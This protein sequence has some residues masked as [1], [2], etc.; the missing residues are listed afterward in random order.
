ADEVIAPWKAFLDR[1]GLDELLVIPDEELA[2]IPFGLLPF[3]DGCLLDRFAIA[4]APSL[5]AWLTPASRAYGE[6]PLFSLANPA[7]GEPGGGLPFAEKEAETLAGLFPGGPEPFVDAAAKRSV[8][9]ELADRA[10][11]LHLATHTRLVPGD[12]LSSALLLT[13][14]EEEGD[15]GRLTAAEI[16]ALPLACELAVLSACETAV[17]EGGDGL[18]FLSLARAFL[19]AGAEAVAATFWR[20]SDI[21]TAITVRNLFLNLAD[22][23][24]PA[25]ALRRAQL[26]TRENFPSPTYWGGFGIFTHRTP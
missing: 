8:Y 25:E 17:P 15:D 13:P 26:E 20:T 16:I 19:Y 23:L 22:G 3:G 9:F 11:R 10:R 18:E 1:P 5:T 24:S 4:Y 21:T 2:Y 6:L 14:L 12:P 7:T